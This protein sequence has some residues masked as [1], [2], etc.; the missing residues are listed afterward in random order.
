MLVLWYPLFEHPCCNA[1]GDVYAKERILRVDDGTLEDAL[2]DILQFIEEF[3]GMVTVKFFE[4]KN[5]KLYGKLYDT[6]DV[7]MS[8]DL[9][10]KFDESQLKSSVSRIKLIRY[11]DDEEHI[12]I[13]INVIKG[14][15]DSNILRDLVKS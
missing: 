13:Q 1:K 7:P 5:G 12:D 9:L 11:I 8:G 6:I 3:T 2:Y 4:N 14:I 10:K 15:Y